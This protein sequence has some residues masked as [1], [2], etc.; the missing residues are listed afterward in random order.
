MGCNT[1]TVWVGGA[2]V[3]VFGVL[4]FSLDFSVVLV[5]WVV[6]LRVLGR[7]RW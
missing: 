1:G 2:T 3:A 4:G 5:L 7:K 6:F